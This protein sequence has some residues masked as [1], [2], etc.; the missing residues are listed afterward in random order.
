VLERIADHIENMAKNYIRLYEIQKNARLEELIKLS[1]TVTDTFEKSIHA[2]F[3]RNSTRAEMIF[4]E[5][6][7]IRKIYSDIS[8]KLF[9]PENIH[10]AILQ[11]AMLDSVG[12][13]AS[14]SEDIAEIAIN[15]SISTH[16]D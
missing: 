2:L 4:E 10:S 13:I 16:Q 6:K 7:E 15:M 12:R 3:E 14:Y 9:E 11:K 8:S 5:L 1:I